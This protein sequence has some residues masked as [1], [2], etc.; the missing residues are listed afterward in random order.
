MRSCDDHDRDDV[1]NKSLAK[2]FSK[3]SGQRAPTYQEQLSQRIRA[4]VQV[5]VNVAVVDLFVVLET[6]VLENLDQNTDQHLR[7]VC[8]VQYLSGQ[9][10]D[11]L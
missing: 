10:V 5:H 4:R 6:D 1:P 2:T 9:P 11:V 7:F 8:L 3:F